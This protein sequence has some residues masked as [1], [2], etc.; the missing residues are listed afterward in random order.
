MAVLDAMNALPIFA[1]GTLDSLPLRSYTVA[2]AN[3][4]VPITSQN[5][6]Y[7]TSVTVI[8][9]NADSASGLSPPANTLLNQSGNTP[10]AQS[11]SGGGGALGSGALL[12]LGTFALARRRRHATR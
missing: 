7:A 12:L 1:S 3:A 8:D 2:D 6:V 5:V 4:G 10:P 11:D 9:A